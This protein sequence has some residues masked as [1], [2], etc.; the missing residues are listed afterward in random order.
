MNIKLKICGITNLDDALY[1]A[2]A[3][4]NALGFVIYEKS[5]R[6]ISIQKATDIIENLPPFVVPVAVTVD[7]DDRL[8]QMLKDAGFSVVQIHGTNCISIQN[9]KKIVSIPYK[10]LKNYSNK[11]DYILIDSA[12]IGG[13]GKPFD[14]SILDCI[15]P[16]KIIVSGGLNRQNIAELLSRY[17]PYAVDLSSSLER[18]PGKK[19]HA[20]VKAFIRLFTHLI[21]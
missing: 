15:P 9:I 19:D 13:T 6:N 18:Y 16:D 17:K 2:D 20:K 1:C 5:P 8:V 11:N 3:G 14:W 10:E 12:I 21:H 4:A 7:P